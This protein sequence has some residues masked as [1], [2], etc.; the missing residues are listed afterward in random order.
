MKQY[1]FKALLSTKCSWWFN[2]DRHVSVVRVCVKN[3]VS[4]IF[5]WITQQIS[6][7]L[8]ECACV[9]LYQNGLE[10]YAE[11]LLPWQPKKYFKMF[12]FQNGIAYSFDIWCV[13][14][15]KNCTVCTPKAKFLCEK[16]WFSCLA[17]F[18]VTGRI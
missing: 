3:A 13:A 15:N 5:S 17:M 10:N 14:L 18:N 1:M 11:L 7:I 16:H 4:N 2:S 12:L 6:Y 8:A 9:N